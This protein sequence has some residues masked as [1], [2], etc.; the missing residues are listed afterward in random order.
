M[1]RSTFFVFM[2]LSSCSMHNGAFDREYNKYLDTKIGISKNNLISSWGATK[3]IKINDR[4]ELFSYERWY[5]TDKTDCGGVGQTHYVVF[6]KHKVNDDISLSLVDGMNYSSNNFD[7]IDTVYVPIIK[8]N[9]HYMPKLY[10]LKNKMKYTINDSLV[11]VGNFSVNTFIKISDIIF[12]FAP[13]TQKIKCPDSYDK[14]DIDIV[15]LTKLDLP[16]KC[17]TNF[18]VEDGKIIKWSHN[19]NSCIL[20]DKA[21]TN[22]N[23]NVNIGLNKI[24]LI[25]KLGQ[26]KF[27]VKLDNNTEVLTY[28]DNKQVSY[29][30]YGQKINYIVAECFTNFTLKN[31]KVEKITQRGNG[32]INSNKKNI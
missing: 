7:T 23:L 19:G 11:S 12:F 25:G 18:L 3:S 13:K 31:N 24:Q 1:R 26:P 15:Q 10:A 4:Q 30:Y 9:I 17:I 8:N 20:T 27:F 6:N 28:Y 2:V 29:D 14:C 16:F 5:G 21:S 32:C 22:D